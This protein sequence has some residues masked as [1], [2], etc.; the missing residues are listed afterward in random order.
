MRKIDETQFVDYTYTDAGFSV[1][2]SNL[3]YIIDLFKERKHGKIT[4]RKIDG[5]IA[6]IDQK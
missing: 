4:G 3:K 1:T 2:M 5:T 6:I